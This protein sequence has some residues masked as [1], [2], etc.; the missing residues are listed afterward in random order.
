[1]IKL[2]ILEREIAKVK[3]AKAKHAGE[4]KGPRRR[5]CFQPI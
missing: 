4:K 3:R 1:M 5:I 2:A